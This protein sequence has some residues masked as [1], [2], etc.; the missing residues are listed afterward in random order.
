MA[1]SQRKTLEWP[2]QVYEENFLFKCPHCGEVDIM[3]TE[4]G[5]IHRPAA[6]PMVKEQKTGVARCRKCRIDWSYKVN[7]M[8]DGEE[9][10]SGRRPAVYLQAVALRKGKDFK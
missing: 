1:V 4:A 7:K 10:E 6:Y 9:L 3:L 2:E 8:K 5:S